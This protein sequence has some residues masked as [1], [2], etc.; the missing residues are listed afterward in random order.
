LVAAIEAPDDEPHLRR[1][2][3]SSLENAWRFTVEVR[4]RHSF[5]VNHYDQVVAGKSFCADKCGGNP[6]L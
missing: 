4:C 1:P 6:G 2:R 3:A 5:G